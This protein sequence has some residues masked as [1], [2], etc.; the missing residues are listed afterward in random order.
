[1]ENKEDLL[2]L[3]YQYNPSPD[4]EDQL[5]QACDII[6]SLILEDKQN[7]LAQLAKGKTC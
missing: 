6:L 1:M 7:K 4:A 5:T 3:E 2:S